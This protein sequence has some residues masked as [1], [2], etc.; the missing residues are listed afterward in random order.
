MSKGELSPLYEKLNFFV[1]TTAPSYSGETFMRGV[2][3]RLQI[4]D[5]LKS[6][7]GFFTSINLSWD[8]SY[9]WQ[10]INED[11]IVRN[12]MVLNVATNFQPVH[13]FNPAINEKFIG[14]AVG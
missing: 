10:I 7:P 9:P 11:E 1:G 13:T 3:C 14:T 5:Y 12:P 8:S 4:G 6:V 2:F